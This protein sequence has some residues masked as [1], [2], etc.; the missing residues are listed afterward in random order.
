MPTGSEY[1]V[2]L[3]N[4]NYWAIETDWYGRFSLWNFYYGDTNL[5]KFI[6]AP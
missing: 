4:A 2:D 3:R 5:G 1:V 6:R